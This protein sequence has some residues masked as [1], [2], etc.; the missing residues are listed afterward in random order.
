MTI[1]P[2][3]RLTV[4]A[5]GLVAIAGFA[6]PAASADTRQVRV[7][8]SDLDLNNPRNAARLSERVEAASA[9]VCTRS[10]DVN[11][12]SILDRRT[13]EADVARCIA[14]AA[15]DAKRQINTRRDFSSLDNG[16]AAN[17]G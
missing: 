12:S 3:F 7:E 14:E 10:G 6:A 5:A 1:L 2:E 4:L 17:A 13:V 9:K 8:I 11:R 16:A 15:E